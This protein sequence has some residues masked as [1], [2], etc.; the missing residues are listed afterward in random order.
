MKHNVNCLKIGKFGFSMKINNTKKY[1][2]PRIPHGVDNVTL[3]RYSF[4]DYK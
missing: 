1:E 3:R 2:N 4:K